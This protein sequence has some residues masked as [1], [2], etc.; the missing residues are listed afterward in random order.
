M[1]YSEF[2]KKS[3]DY[4]FNNQANL[5]LFREHQEEFSYNQKY[6]MNLLV[7]LNKSKMTREAITAIWKVADKHFD[8]SDE[9]KEKL[10]RIVATTA[11]LISDVSGN[12]ERN[13]SQT[14]DLY[15]YSILLYPKETTYYQQIIFKLKR[16]KNWM[17]MMEYAI[18]WYNISTQSKGSIV[19]LICEA[20]I[21]LKK[22]KTVLHY[23]TLF[24]RDK[25]ISKINVNLK[26]DYLTA[27]IISLLNRESITFEQK[28]L[29]IKISNYWLTE[30]ITYD[31]KVTNLV[32]QNIDKI[33][34][35]Q[36]I[37]TSVPEEQTISVV[38]T[39][40]PTENLKPGISVDSSP[41]YY[42]PIMEEQYPIDIL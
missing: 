41:T 5:Q 21:Q 3:Y 1:T 4:T 32:N 37:T 6:W 40:I 10:A 9:E 12:L 35:M 22:Y 33:R 38:P 30:H 23:C 20:A 11:W 8:F 16:Q 18:K 19:E 24:F 14:I 15:K 31:E 39:Q 42:N 2:E 26:R 36:N 27:S 29:T 13:I 28:D 25:E 34:K 7:L 17:E